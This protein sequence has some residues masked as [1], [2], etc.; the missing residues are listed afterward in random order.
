MLKNKTAKN[1]KEILFSLSKITLHYNADDDSAIDF[2]KSLQEGHKRTKLFLGYD[3][4]EDVEI[5]LVYSR[6]EMDKALGRE[7]PNWFV[8]VTNQTTG[9]III[10][11]PSAVEE[12]STHNRVSILQTMKHELVHAFE[13]TYGGGYVAW[14]L[15]EGIAIIVA[16]QDKKHGKKHLKNLLKTGKFFQYSTD[17]YRFCT[18]NGGY[19]ASKYLTEKLIEDFGQKKV[20]GL[21]S[22]DC[23]ESNFNLFFEKVIG[24]SPEEYA[25]KITK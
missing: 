4:K 19:K 23:K 3:L 17:N 16:E 18:N 12:Y 14:W 1:K 13:I 22:N 24:I 20:V 7:T 6:K 25:K 21:M 10:F 15:S 9:N 8:G 5:T 11:S 2:I